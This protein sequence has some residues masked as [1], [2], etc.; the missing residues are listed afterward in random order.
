MSAW[1]S[2]TC[3]T[4][5]ALSGPNASSSRRSATASSAS[6]PR[7]VFWSQPAR[8]AEIDRD[9]V[10][11][12]QLRDARDRGLQR[13]RQGKLGDRLAEHRE[14]RLGPLELERRGARALAGPQGLRRPDGERAQPIEVA[15]RRR[16]RRREDELEDAEWRLAER[17]RRDR[18]SPHRLDPHG[19]V[20]DWP[21]RR[22]RVERLE[23]ARR[24][25]RLELPALG[26]VPEPRRL[27]AG[28]TRS[29]PH[30]LVRPACL[31]E[32]GTERVACELEP[33]AYTRA[34]PAVPRAERP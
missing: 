7:A 11:A 14:Q 26:D 13:V 25:Q 28:R 21:R 5:C 27:C 12:E 33:V 18:P 22:I 23:P 6:A 10:R 2:T 34:F 32:R 15:L 19:L 31:L 29:D 3:R 8:V 30:D 16:A 17:E 4:P 20:L 9:A 24:R 1:A